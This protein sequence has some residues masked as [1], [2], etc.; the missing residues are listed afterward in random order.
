M[1]LIDSI[2]QSMFKDVWVIGF[3]VMLSNFCF[4]NS[5]LNFLM[6]SSCY[7]ITPSILEYV[8]FK[9]FNTN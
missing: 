5:N 2:W 6:K 9:V 3:V 4:W 8:T 1:E 7:Y